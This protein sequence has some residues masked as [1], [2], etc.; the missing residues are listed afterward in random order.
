MASKI[1]MNTSK[2]ALFASVAL[3]LFS[4]FK[5]IQRLNIYTYC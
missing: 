4:Q 3:A 5:L 1:L 2:Y